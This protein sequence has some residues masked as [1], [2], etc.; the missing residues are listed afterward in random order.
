MAT[1]TG[2]GPGGADRRGKSASGRVSAKGSPQRPGS[3]IGRY[4]TAEESGRYTR[5]IP[6]TIRHSPRW[7]GATILG[8]LLGG[9][10]TILLNYL[11]V[12]PGSVSIWYLVAGLVV[13][14]V[15]FLMATGYR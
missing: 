5:P 8:L 10:L 6:R 7:Y 13:I 4:K 11:S 9:V 2:S 12:L 1:K 14:F 3:K 15:G